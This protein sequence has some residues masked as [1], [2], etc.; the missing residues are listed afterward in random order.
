MMHCSSLG[1]AARLTCPRHT[2]TAVL[3]MH[4]GVRHLVTGTQGVPLH[5]H[6]RASHSTV[7]P[8]RSYA[9]DAPQNGAASKVFT[10]WKVRWLLRVIWH[11]IGFVLA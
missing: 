9:N 2:G 11:C 1:R 7:M 5:R 8:I 3:S 4:A 6:S 10:D